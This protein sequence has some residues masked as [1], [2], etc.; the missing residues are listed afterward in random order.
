MSSLITASI[1]LT[2]PLFIR[3]TFNLCRGI[4][5]NEEGNP[6]G[7]YKWIET[8]GYIYDVFFYIAGTLIPLGTQLSSLIYGH[9]RKKK[10]DKYKLNYVIENDSLGHHEPTTDI[11]SSDDEELDQSRYFNP[12]YSNLSKS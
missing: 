4:A 2:L 10:K 11:D 7:F 8:T 6:V 1:F 12:S 9:I 5:H 3:G